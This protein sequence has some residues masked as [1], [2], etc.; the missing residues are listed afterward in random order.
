M[1]PI[2][3]INDILKFFEG[4]KADQGKQMTH[5]DAEIL[6]EVNGV[7]AA[8][9]IPGAVIGHGGIISPPP[10]NA[11]IGID[12]KSAIFSVKGVFIMI[13]LVFIG[14]KIYKHVTE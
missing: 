10:G 3:M 4:L 13:V 14:A 2:A 8:S 11:V 6:A 1:D 12:I 5:Q 7:A 9:G